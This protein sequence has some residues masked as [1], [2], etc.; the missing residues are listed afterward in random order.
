MLV[1]IGAVRADGE[2]TG[3]SVE[4]AQLVEVV[5]GLREGNVSDAKNVLVA[6]GTQAVPNLAELIRKGDA[7][8]RSAS[9]EAIEAIG[10]ADS[11]TVDL[12]RDVFKGDPQPFIR[13][14]AAKVLSIIDV[15]RERADEVVGKILYDSSVVHSLGHYAMPALLNLYHQTLLYTEDN[16]FDKADRIEELIIELGEAAVPDLVSELAPAGKRF[17][18]KA[19]ELLGRIGSVAKNDAE[20]PLIIALD[21]TP[22]ASGQALVKIGAGDDAVPALKRIV[23]TLAE[24]AGWNSALNYVDAIGGSAYYESLGEAAIPELIKVLSKGSPRARTRAAELLGYIGRKAAPAVGALIKNLGIEGIYHIENAL[25]RIGPNAADAIPHLADRAF[26]SKREYPDRGAMDALRKITP[27]SAPLLLYATDGNTDPN[28]RSVALERLK[29]LGSV[30]YNPTGDLLHLVEKG[31]NRTRKKAI[32][33]LGENYVD[34]ERAVPVLVGVLGDK[35][36]EIQSDAIKSLGKLAPRSGQ[37][38][39]VLLKRLKT[40]ENWV[41]VSLKQAIIVCRN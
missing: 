37:A 31:D 19:A 35:D 2:E 16:S 27:Y 34:P 17:P 39:E 23:E 6:H 22:K 20:K 24:K 30:P 28:A 8:F 12:L 21:H 5:A 4:I 18:E 13:L 26:N 1:T 29:K 10:S 32:N 15:E 38:L 36:Y 25:G 11:G 3:Q 41:G 14:Q 7:D 9:I 33:L 40:T